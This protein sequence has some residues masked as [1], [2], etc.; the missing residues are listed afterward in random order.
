M[1]RD[2]NH[3]LVGKANQAKKKKIYIYIKGSRSYLFEMLLWWRQRSTALFRLI[4]L[5]LRPLRALLERVTNAPGTVIS[6]S[7]CFN[8][9]GGWTFTIE[10]RITVINPP[11]PSPFFLLPPPFFLPLFPLFWSFFFL[12][13][14]FFGDPIIAVTICNCLELSRLQLNNETPISFPVGYWLNG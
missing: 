4:C 14:C 1:R 11:F 5:S 12:F 10:C 13:Y 3:K 7:F 6:F 9:D 2:G 8:C